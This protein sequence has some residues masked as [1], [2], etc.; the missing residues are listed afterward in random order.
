MKKPSE[1]WEQHIQDHLEK[2]EF[3]SLIQLEYFKHYNVDSEFDFLEDLPESLREKRR[4]LGLA[5]LIDETEL[6]QQILLNHKQLILDLEES[7][8]KEIKDL[9]VKH[10]G[11]NFKDG[12][13]YEEVLGYDNV[14]SETYIPDKQINYGQL[15]NHLGNQKVLK[16]ENF[17]HSKIIKIEFPA[18]NENNI[19]HP[20]TLGEMMD[21]VIEDLYA[22]PFFLERSTTLDY[23]GTLYFL[24]SNYISDEARE[25]LEDYFYEKYS[26]VLRVK[27]KEETCTLPFSKNQ[28]Y[29][30]TWNSNSL[31]KINLVSLKELRNHIS[32]ISPSPTTQIEKITGNIFSGQ[33]LASSRKTFLPPD[34]YIRKHYS[35]GRGTRFVTWRKIALYCAS[36]KITFEDFLFYLYESNDGTSKDMELWGENLIRKH[37]ENMYQFAL[38][39]ADSKFIERSEKKECIE[40]KDIKKQKKEY[41]IKD[42]GISEISKNKEL[43]FQLTKYLNREY[44]KLYKSP[45]QRRQWKDK[46]IQDSVI[47]LEFLLRKQQ[48]DKKSKKAYLEDQFKDLEGG[49]SIPV[50]MQKDLSSYLHL[51]I[52]IKKIL[53]FLEQIHLIEPISINGYS[54][55]YKKKKFSKH[56]TLKIN[57]SLILKL[58]Y[59]VTKGSLSLFPSGKI[60]NASN[61]NY[62]SNV[63]DFIRQAYQKSQ[64]LQGNFLK[65]APL[66]V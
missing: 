30:G 39:V 47:L 20:L 14:Y 60:L 44:L 3:T 61:I 6:F 48:W 9:L 53:T 19:T 64:Y 40:T 29:Y 11:F 34:D 65:K 4:D 10:F 58:L 37:A 16:T 57:L 18:K 56:F 15:A 35:Y 13:L 5:P 50:S 21:T 45:K 25:K 1:I 55:S 28:L 54:F 7:P 26:I 52:N 46:F 41:T 63:T 62:V 2:I 22:E 51:K 49:V 43:K 42:F 36:R 24:F 32:S 31:C 8:K 33:V 12:K 38:S 17:L 66:G 23:R 27:K 59:Y